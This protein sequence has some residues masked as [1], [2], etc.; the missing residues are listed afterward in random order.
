MGVPI[1][2]TWR[3]KP[4]LSHH[5]GNHDLRSAQHFSRTFHLLCLPFQAQARPPAPKGSPCASPDLSH[6]PMLWLQLPL[7]PTILWLPPSNSKSLQPAQ[8]TTIT[9]HL[10]LSTETIPLISDLLPHFSFL[11]SRGFSAQ[12]LMLQCSLHCRVQLL[13][14]FPR[15]VVGPQQFCICPFLCCSRFPLLAEISRLSVGAPVSQHRG[16]P[17]LA[18]RLGPQHIQLTCRCERPMASHLQTSL[19]II[20]CKNSL[21]TRHRL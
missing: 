4:F 2:W 20:A 7:L 21:C 8:F 6:L 10:S 17:E 13:S 11:S 19:S 12:A 5:Q 14:G 9:T 1:A 18:C 15:A 16:I 3:R